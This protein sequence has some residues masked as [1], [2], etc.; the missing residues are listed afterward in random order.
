MKLEKKYQTYFPH[1]TEVHCIVDLY[2]GLNLHNIYSGP[3]R[4]IFWLMNER[5]ANFR[6]TSSPKTCSY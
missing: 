4:H 2:L 5:D 6:L 1:Y 3:E